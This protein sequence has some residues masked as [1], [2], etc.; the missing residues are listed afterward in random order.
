MYDR[1]L[2]AFVKVAQL[3]SFSKAAN[4]LYVSAPAVIKQI[5]LLER[6]MGFTLLERSRSG[7]ALTP[8]GKAVYEGALDIMERSRNVVARARQTAG[9]TPRV[10]RLAV[11]VL[12]PAR[13]VARLWR[14]KAD[15]HPDIRLS[16]VRVS[17]DFETWSDTLRRIGEEIDVSVVIT[18]TTSPTC[19]YEAQEIYRE[20]LCVAVPAAHRLA[21]K[22][23]LSIE[24]LYGE[25][26]SMAPLGTTPYVDD[27]C[28][29]LVAEHPQ[30]VPD[31]RYPYDLTEFN[32]CADE[33]ELLLSCHDWDDVHPEM[34]NKEV[35]WSGWHGQL[36]FSIL[37]PKE[38]A[39]HVREFVDVICQAS[40][41][42]L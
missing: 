16:T 27:L 14:T 24:D 26:I 42:Q 41:E 36:G 8:A 9:T 12:R 38:S 37:F 4:V 5:N 13:T 20:P 7:V 3:G 29:Y 1:H 25:R 11:S 17:D 28:A 30:V 32:R 2:D 22:D 19:G 15:E 6:E 23:R 10:V 40:A 39:P 35:D 18:P 33:H 31:A 21:A 34:L